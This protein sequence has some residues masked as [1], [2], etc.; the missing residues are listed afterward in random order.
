MLQKELNVQVSGKG[1]LGVVQ[2]AFLGNWR[3]YGFEWDLWGFSGEKRAKKDP[4]FEMIQ[5]VQTWS[6]FGNE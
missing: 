1:Y 4:N 2:G 6:R 5:D 3:D